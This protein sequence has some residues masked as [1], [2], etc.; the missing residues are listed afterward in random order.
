MLAAIE[1]KQRQEMV[2]KGLDPVAMEIPGAK[3]TKKLVAKGGG[4]K[5]AAKVVVDQSMRRRSLRHQNKGGDGEGGSGAGVV[6]GVDGDVDMQ[7]GE[8]FCP[9]EG[10]GEDAGNGDIN[11]QDGDESRAPGAKDNGDVHTRNADISREIADDISTKSTTGPSAVAPTMSTLATPQQPAFVSAASSKS[12]T[13]IGKWLQ[14]PLG[15]ISKCDLGEAYANMVARLCDLERLYNFVNKTRGF[16]KVCKK[17]PAELDHW[18]HDGRGRGAPPVVSNVSQFATTWNDWWSE[19]Q[20][21]WRRGKDGLLR[22]EYGD[23]WELLY[24][25][26]A[27]GMLGPVACL[28]WWGVAVLSEDESSVEAN[29]PVAVWTEAVKDVTWVLEGLIRHANGQH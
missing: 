16:P 2:N 24:A 21:V 13:N 4:K 12:D 28:Y 17:R 18:V 3:V 9:L 22:E 15:E 5:K 19:L 7:N 26:G 25:P 20:P 29:G 23:N 11:M 6:L 27:N 8:R 14:K 1:E 10:E